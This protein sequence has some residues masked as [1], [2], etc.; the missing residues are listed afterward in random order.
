MIFGLPAHPLV[1]HA[2]VVLLPVTGLA[3]LAVLASA[4]FRTWLGWGL[5]VLGVATAVAALVTKQT[6]ETLV[7]DPGAAVG[8]LADHT[9]WGGLTGVIGA[10]FGAVTVL[11]WLVTAPAVRTRVPVLDM[12][13]L[14]VVVSVAA[15]ALASATVVLTVLAGHSGATSV[16]G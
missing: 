16:W 2:T 5:P 4:R 6:G 3:V 13:L 14:R 11:L 9:H 8:A 10:T 7:G 1:V 15:A 12:R